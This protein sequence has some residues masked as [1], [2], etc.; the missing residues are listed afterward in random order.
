[1]ISKLEDLIGPFRGKSVCLLGLSFKPDTDDIREAPS[2]DMIGRCWREGPRCAPAT[3][4]PTS[5]PGHS[6]PD[7]L[8]FEDPYAAAEG[9]DAVVLLTEW[10]EFRNIDLPR[11]RE[12]L[13]A[14]KFLDCRNVYEPRRMGELGFEYVSVGR[15]PR[16]PGEEG[17]E[18]DWSSPVRFAPCVPERKMKRILVTG[19]CGFI[20]SNFVR[21][22][23]ARYPDCNVT[24]LDKLTYAGNLE[25]LADLEGD[26]R[27]RFV[28]GD[29]CDPQAVD[30]LVEEADAVVHFAAESHVDRSL[31]G[32]AEF[33]RTN[34]YG[35]A[36]LLE[37]ARRYGVERF[38][39]V[40]TD[41]VYG[42]VEEGAWTEESPVDPR[43]PYSASKASADI[44]VRAYHVNHGLPAVI[45]RASNNIGPY[46]YPEKR[47]PLYITNAIDD[48]PL[49]VY[50]DGRQVRDHLHVEDHCEAIDLV[51]R[52]GQV[53]EVY[54]VGGRT[55]RT[56]SRSRA[57][58]SGSSAS[59]NR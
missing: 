37:A 20:G 12:A 54:N 1:M 24:N 48:R 16:A 52:Q 8:C 23:L 31:L 29:V 46:Q 32:G 13:R 30:P 27:Y 22:L 14:A 2:L 41:E 55:S 9:C 10:N 6:F 38:H 25:N 11:L 49:P 5:A 59:R 43:N 39:Q 36:V 4:P 21:Y 47:V 18:P 15:R 40:S 57:R 34:V 35:T 58:F 42:S 28:R 26:R 17:E 50:G 7:I 19:G 56:A 45:T 33:V 53:G 44:L 3:R 51:L